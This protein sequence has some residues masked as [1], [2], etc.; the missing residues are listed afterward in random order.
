MNV[1]EK[2]DSLTLDLLSCIQENHSVSQRR[3]AKRLGVALGVANSYIKKCIQKGLLKVEQAPANRYFYYLTPHGLAEKSRLTK[4]YVVS[5]FHHYRAAKISLGKIFEECR[6]LNQKNTVLFGV[7]ELSE[8]AVLLST[9]YDVK[10]DSIF[11]PDF[12]EVTFLKKTLSRDVLEIERGSVIIL[13]C[14]DRFDFFHK[15]AQE[16]T[17]PERILVPDLLDNLR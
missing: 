4:H 6:L 16:I 15:I 1:K 14:L 2:Q 11:D 9:Q 8:M 10:I 3:V 12:A 7:S 13:T 17:S 5:L